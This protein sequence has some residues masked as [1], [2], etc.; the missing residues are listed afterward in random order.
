MKKAI[1]YIFVKLFKILSVIGIHIKNHQD[2]RKVL[3]ESIFPYFKE[4]DEFTNI[5]FIGCDWYTKSYNRVFRKKNYW[6]ID[7]NPKMKKY[8]SK[9]HI[10]D[11]MENLLQYF[12]KNKVDLIICN[13][14]FGWGLN[15][16]ESAENSFKSCY[17]LL[18]KD[19]VFILGW[20]DLPQYRPI[21]L[22]DV[23]ALNLFKPLNFEPL[24]TVKI[25]TKNPNR[26]T[27]NF[28]IKAD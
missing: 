10:V 27:Y 13:G 17:D 26:H 2:D 6:T 20:N 16:Q 19:G 11:S 23:Q 25:L 4:K 7:L 18:R 21:L 3:E 8:G 1:G 14:V 5:I 28:Y 12:E 22:E 15:K 9:K 24:N